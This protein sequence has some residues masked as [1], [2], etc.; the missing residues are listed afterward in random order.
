MRQFLPILFLLI[1]LAILTSASYY[2][3]KRF[4]WYF[5]LEAPKLLFLLFAFVS[6]FMLAGVLVFSN[7]TNGFYSILYILAAFLMGFFLYFLLNVLLVDVLRLFTTLSPKTYGFLALSITLLLSLYGIVHARNVQVT[8]QE[9]VIKG[10]T[11]EVKAM[12]LTDLH[13]GHFRGKKYLQ[14]I[15]D[16][17][18]EQEV[19]VVFIT[20]DL[21][22]GRINLSLETLEPLTQLHVPV[23]F[24]EGN[25]DA[26]TG[27]KIIKNYLRQ[28]NVQVLENEVA[29]WNDIQIVG[30]NHML[31]DKNSNN[32]HAAGRSSTIEET[33][34]KLSI[35]KNIPS[36]LLHH[37]PDGIQYAN[38]SGIDL[39]LAGHTH[40]GQLFPIKYF[41]N[42]LFKYNKGYHNF[43]GTQLYVSQGSGTFGPPMRVGTKS[44][45]ALLV[46]IPGN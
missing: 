36:I 19:D 10:L 42:M 23:F 26:Y 35:N 45:M 44:E 22:D 16:K 30:L 15:V 1:F 2:L 20:G 13:I 37:S 14:R 32:M 39:Y 9:I 46:L 8:K 25:H 29:I 34:T 18:N 40:A 17:T 5:S 6:V 31:A 43:N 38:Q 3:S 21:F 33:L 27:V 41:A 24:V 28:L 7:T 11:K 12:H 4:N